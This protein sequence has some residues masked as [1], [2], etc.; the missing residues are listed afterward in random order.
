MTVDEIIREYK[1]WMELSSEV[2]EV[3]YCRILCVDQKTDEEFEMTVRHLGSKPTLANVLTLLGRMAWEHEKSK[4]RREPGQSRGARA[5]LAS[6]RRWC[7]LY[8]HDENSPAVHE[9]YIAMRKRSQQLKY[10][11]GEEAYKKLLEAV[12]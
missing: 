6:F 5:D 12:K 8:G 11:L 4:M 7:F 10:V 3:Y 9:R 2:P 1:P